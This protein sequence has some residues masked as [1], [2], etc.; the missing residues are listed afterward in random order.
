MSID[1]SKVA[2]QETGVGVD[3]ELTCLEPRGAAFFRS[4]WMGAP[5]TPQGTALTHVL[6]AFSVYAS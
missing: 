3:S 5:G 2:E 1:Y 6:P 4:L